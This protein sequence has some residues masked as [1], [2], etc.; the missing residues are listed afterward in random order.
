MMTTI[1]IPLSEERLN[2]L[3]RWAKQAGMAPEEYLR[4]RIE[5]LLD[6]PDE[7]FRVAAEYVLQKNAELYRRLA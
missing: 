4:R 2:Q 3:Q 7:H 5:E 1:I 6:R